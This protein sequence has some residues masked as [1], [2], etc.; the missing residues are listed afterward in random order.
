MSTEKSSTRAEVVWA[1]HCKEETAIWTTTTT[2]ALLRRQHDRS[3]ER[4]KLQRNANTR[5]SPEKA[6]LGEDITGHLQVW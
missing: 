1:G 6:M 3:I 2:A 4:D 5:G